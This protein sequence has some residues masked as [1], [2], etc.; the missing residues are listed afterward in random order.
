MSAAEPKGEQTAG[1]AS[2]SAEK[3]SSTVEDAAENVKDS[4]EQRSGEARKWIDDW[5]KEQT[6]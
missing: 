5:K 6:D 2:N 4:I 1:K 3:A